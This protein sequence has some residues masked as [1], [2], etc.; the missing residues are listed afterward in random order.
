VSCRGAVL[1]TTG[2][3]GR[4]RPT[5]QQ[6]RHSECNPPK[7][8]LGKPSPLLCE[9]PGAAPEGRAAGYP[10]SPMAVEVLRTVDKPADDPGIGGKGSPIFIAGRGNWL[11]SP[12]G[13][14]LAAMADLKNTSPDHWSAPMFSSGTADP[15]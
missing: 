5:T 14:S 1:P 3:P 6:H 9:A 8:R 7:A 11:E 15:Q 10:D 12:L 4:T 2:A 13:L